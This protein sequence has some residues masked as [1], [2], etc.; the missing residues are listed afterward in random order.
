M[1]PEPERR[2][3]THVLPQDLEEHVLL[4]G[5]EHPS[6]VVDIV[7]EFAQSQE[8]ANRRGFLTYRCKTEKGNTFTLGVTGV[9]PSATEIAVLEY[10]SCGARMFLRAGTSAAAPN[11]SQHLGDIVVTK[12]AIRYDGVS[13]LYVGKKVRA[14]ATRKIVDELEHAARELEIGFRTGLTLTSAGYYVTS[15]IFSGPSDECVG[16]AVR[17]VKPIALMKFL[18]L[19]SIKKIL[20]IEMETATLLTLSKIYGLKAGAVSGLSSLS[21]NNPSEQIEDAETALRNAIRVGITALDYLKTEKCPK[22]VAR[23]SYSVEPF[24]T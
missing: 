5:G 10:A 22:M 16:G 2:P 21:W 12:E 8:V 11:T 24:S 17:V 1:I 19:L 18:R 15:N 6:L 14:L 20:N 4:I 13:D 3:N 7:R 23:G 9:G